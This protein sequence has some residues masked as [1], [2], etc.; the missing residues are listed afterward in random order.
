MNPDRL[1]NGFNS[2]ETIEGKSY[3]YKDENYSPCHLKC[4]IKDTLIAEMNLMGLVNL[5]LR[6]QQPKIRFKYF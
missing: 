1:G 3:I 5:S 4:L 2:L 6:K